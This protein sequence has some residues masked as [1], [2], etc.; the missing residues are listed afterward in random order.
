MILINKKNYQMKKKRKIK[1]KELKYQK[2]MI[3]KKKEIK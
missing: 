3:L 2:K 1:I